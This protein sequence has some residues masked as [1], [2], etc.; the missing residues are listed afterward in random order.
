MQTV[1]QGDRVQIHYVK[2][3]QD[4]SMT[5]SRHRAPIELTVGVD[6]PRLPGL[7]LELVGLA[8]GSSL[9]VS[10]PAERAYGKSDSTRVRRWSRTRFAKGLD[11]PIGKWVRLLNRRGRPRLVRILGIRG[12]MVL[13]D[14]NHRWAGQ[15][16]EV[17]I[18]LV[19]IQPVEAAMKTDDPR[20]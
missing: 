14:T 13:V 7:G 20:D 6:H 1:Q 4:G 18:E 12:E 16:M 2:R 10:V 19:S 3:F 8:T 9:T 15:T 11:L 17:E 5:S